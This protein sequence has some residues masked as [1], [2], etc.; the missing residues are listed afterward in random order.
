MSE[1]GRRVL[2]ECEHVQ[3]C[4]AFCIEQAQKRFS[5]LC[6]LTPHDPLGEHMS[7][8]EVRVRAAIG[9]LGTMLGEVNCLREAFASH[10]QDNRL[11]N[12]AVPADLAAAI[13]RFPY[14]FPVRLM[15][16]IDLW[17]FDSEKRDL[18]RKVM[19]AWEAAF[20]A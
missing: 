5:R 7:G 6:S 14:E 9:A 17:Y 1:V 20:A 4:L 3:I 19:L 15:Q 2:H 10:T 12:R 11:D 13:S 18:G 8:P 16:V